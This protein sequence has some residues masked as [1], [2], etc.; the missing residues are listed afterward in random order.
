MKNKNKII[1]IVSSILNLA[2]TILFFINYMKLVNAIP[3]IGDNP[4]KWYHH[5]ILI[6]GYIVSIGVLDLIVWGLV[7]IIYTDFIPFLIENIV[8]LASAGGAIAIFTNGIDNATDVITRGSLI[9][10]AV[11]LS[12]VAL[13]FFIIIIKNTI[14]D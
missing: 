7:S 3:S 13:V 4:I 9:V 14:Q 10:L 2:W 5:L 8:M 1:I 11:I 12:V 6:F